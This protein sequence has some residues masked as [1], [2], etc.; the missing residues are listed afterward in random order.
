MTDETRTN[1]RGIRTTK[2]QFFFDN[3]RRFPSVQVEMGASGDFKGTFPC[4]TH[5]VDDKKQG[6]TGRQ[7]YK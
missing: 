5:V 7:K 4:S 3:E 6:Q 2:D 1:E